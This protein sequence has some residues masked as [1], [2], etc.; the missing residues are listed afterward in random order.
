MLYSDAVH[1]PRITRQ[2]SDVTIDHKCGAK[3]IFSVEPE[4]S[5]FKY[6][7]TCTSGNCKVDIR[8]K[9]RLVIPAEKTEG[10]ATFQCIV[11]N[12]VGEV[13]SN[14][15]QLIVRKLITNTYILLKISRQALENLLSIQSRNC[16]IVLPKYI[17]IRYEHTLIHVPSTCYT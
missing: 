8:D 4:D 2:P 17:S 9:S 12:D 5:S 3:A 10:N 6:E 7:W 1:P 11:S 14:I 13:R 16:Y 15:V